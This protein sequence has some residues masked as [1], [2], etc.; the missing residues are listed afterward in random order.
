VGRGGPMGVERAAAS[1][2]ERIGVFRALRDQ[3]HAIVPPPTCE[4]AHLTL[5]RWLGRLLDCCE[6]LLT[7]GTTGDVTELGRALT[8]LDESREYARGFNVK[9]AALV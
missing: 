8:L 5:G 2:N 4:V 7:V 1:G 3:V 9:H 6:V